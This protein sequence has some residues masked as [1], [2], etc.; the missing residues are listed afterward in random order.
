MK[1]LAFNFRRTLSA[2]LCALALATTAS[3]Q[4]AASPWVTVAP[5]DEA[6]T[7]SMPRAPFP[8]A[9]RGTAGELNVAGR[10]YSLRQDDAEYTVWSFKA[11]NL[12]GAHGDRRAYLDRCAEI[13]WGLLIEPYWKKLERASP[14]ELMKYRLTYE[15]ELPSTGHP[16]RSYFLDLGEQEGITYIYAVG[17]QIYIVAAAGA[18]RESAGV[19]RFIKSFTPN[20]PVP[21]VPYGRPVGTGGGGSGE[22]SGVGSGAGNGIGMGTGSGVGSGEGSGVGPGRGGD[23]AGGNRDSG[24]EAKET[25]YSRTFTAREVTRKARILAKPEP[26]YPEWARRFGVT[27][28]VRVRAVLG[29]SGEVKGV[30]VVTRLPHGLTQKAVEAARKIKFEP[31]LKD[32]RPVTQYVLVEYNFNLY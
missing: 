16:G 23:N 6:F 30:A 14:Q 9:E 22:G 7:V 28:T 8:V 18:A 29:A 19:E 17:S 27:G 20:L 15:G 10:R 4:E 11:A 3:A 24:G 5:P 26:N 12:P 31:A 2:L 13:A 21:G 1:S 25:D 32:G